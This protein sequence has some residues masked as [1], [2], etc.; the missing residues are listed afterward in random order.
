MSNSP[1]FTE[2]QNSIGKDTISRKTSFLNIFAS[3]FISLAGVVVFTLSKSFDNSSTLQTALFVIGL[4]LIIAGLFLLLSKSRQ[5]VYSPTQSVLIGKNI[6]VA[7]SDA[8]AI[9]AMLD[10]NSTDKL[11]PVEQLE[12]GSSYVELVFSRDVNFL[13]VQLLQFSAFCYQPISPVYTFTNE[14]AKLLYN[15]LNSNKTV[16]EC[17]I[18]ATKQAT[19]LSSK[20]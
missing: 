1:L 4:V 17:A 15:C 7:D 5:W 2:L 16:K 12:T 3:I 13:A 20:S 14:K 18:L 19:I 11:Q 6:Y 8:V 9:K 10:D